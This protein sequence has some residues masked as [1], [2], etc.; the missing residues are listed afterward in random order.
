[1]RA[2]T[3]KQI[4]TS[5]IF[6]ENW[7]YRTHA[8]STYKWVSHSTYLLESH[9][10]PLGTIL[11]ILPLQHDPNSSILLLASQPLLSIVLLV[12]S[13]EPRF[14]KAS[15]SLTNI[16]R[17]RFRFPANNRAVKKRHGLKPLPTAEF[18][19]PKNEFL[20]VLNREYSYA[21]ATN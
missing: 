8:Y 20:T 16:Q 5:E 6:T 3:V 14:Y 21:T 19:Y 1:M 10:S 13:K 7:L 9:S 11:L 4:S 15:G 2:T 17:P 18:K 12:E